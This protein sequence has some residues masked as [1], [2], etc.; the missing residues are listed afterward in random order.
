MWIEHGAR[1]YFEGVGDDLDLDVGDER[2][3]TFPEMAQTEQ[4]ETLVFA[5]K[6]YR[7]KEYRDEVNAAVMADMEDRGMDQCHST[8]SAWRTVA[9]ALSSV[10]G[11]DERD[12]SMKTDLSLETKPLRSAL[13]VGETVSETANRRVT[14]N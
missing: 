7:S 11:I 4:D 8:W 14:A 2:V 10:M 9:S 1:E 5:F 13:P 12:Q 6:V 3:R